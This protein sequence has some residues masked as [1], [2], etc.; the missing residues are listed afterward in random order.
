MGGQ[1]PAQYGNNIAWTLIA[2]ERMARQS[3]SEQPFLGQQL[4]AMRQQGL[5]NGQAGFNPMFSGGFPAG[6]NG[7]GAFMGQP[8]VNGAFMGQPGAVNGGFMGQP[9]TGN[10]AFVG[11]QGF[12]GA[13]VNGGFAR[14]K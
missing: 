6:F 3:A 4:T 12:G 7:N 9:A 2:N 11:Q 14:R 10:G 1:V 13:P 5:Y 8:A